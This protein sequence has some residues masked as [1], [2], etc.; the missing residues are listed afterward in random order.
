MEL[1]DV[2]Q[3]IFQVRRSSALTLELEGFLL[4]CRSRNLAAGTLRFYEQKLRPMLAWLEQHGITSPDEIKPLHIRAWIVELADG[5]H[6]AGG[7]HAYYR[8]AKA[9]CSWLEAEG[10]VE[11]SP[12]KRVRG[13]KLPEEP[14]EPVSIEHVRAMLRTCD[15]EHL[16][17]LRDAAI[18]LA[19]LD[20]GCR[21]T[22]LT[23]LTYGDANLK[24]GALLI[25][26]GKGRKPRMVYLG[27]TS[28]R[29]V[30]KYLRK[31]GQPQDGEPL[32]ATSQGTQFT[33]FGLR[34]VI[35]RRAGQ[36]GIEVPTLHSFRRAFALTCLRN[37]VDVY[38]L[39]KLMGHTSLAVLRRYLAQTEDDLQRA[40]ERGGPVDGLAG[41]R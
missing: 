35:E 41:A 33:Y 16:L 32:F 19:L 14:L 7:V 36:A 18:L 29:A 3:R 23:A 30:L 12:M 15:G 11:T 37:N 21:A 10:S 31:R 1:Q 38:S 24:T 8:A 5:A 39:Q 20:T 4:D 25:R 40:H 17:D 26:S 27:V 9:F 28:R 6:S 22:E 13:P 34:S 2:T